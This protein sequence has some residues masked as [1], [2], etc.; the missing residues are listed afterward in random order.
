M[1]K[2]VNRTLDVLAIAVFLVGTSIAIPV[3]GIA[4]ETHSV[5]ITKK[6]QRRADRQLSKDVRRAL[7]ARHIDTAN[8]LITAQRGVITLHGTVPEPGQIEKASEVT[9]AFPGVQSVKIY[10][11]PYINGH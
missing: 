11:T 2:K 5:P 3:V 9:K 10:L 6:E 8:M 4:Q 7:E 1:N